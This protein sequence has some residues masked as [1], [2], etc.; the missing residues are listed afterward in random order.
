MDTA[1]AATSG[2]ERLRE[3]AANLSLHR[4][5]AEVVASLEAGHGG[6]LGGVWGSSRALVAAA[7]ARECPGPL[8]IVAPHPGEIDSIA[9]DLAIFSDA[10][11]AE[12]PAWESEPGERVVHDEIYGGRLRVLKA[13]AHGIPFS[14]APQ[15]PALPAVETRESGNGEDG[16]G[17]GGADA[18]TNR[19]KN[20]GQNPRQSRGLT[21]G[22]ALNPSSGIIVTSIQSLL[23]PVPGRDVLAEATREIRV[24]TALDEQEF[25]KWLVARGGHSTTAVELPGEFSLRGGILDIFPPDAD[26]PVRVELFGSDVESIRRFDVA[27]QRSLGALDAVEVTMLEPTASDRAHFTAYLPP[28]T[29]FLLI[30]PNELAEEGKFYLDRMDRPQ[31]FHSVRTTLDEIYKFPSVTAA[32]VPSGSMEQTAHLEF[33]S[34]ERFSGDI[35]K[36]RDE[37][38][39]VSVGQSVYIVCETVAEVER[40]SELFKTP[41]KEGPKKG[42]S[43]R[44]SD[45]ESSAID[46]APGKKVTVTDLHDLHFV[47]GHLT[48]GFRIV[49]QK[50]ALVSAAELFQRKDLTRSTRR[51]QSR[52][53][54][55]F[56]ELRQGDLV[57][58]LAHGIGRYRGLKLLEKDGRAEEHLELEYHGGTKIF[59]PSA[60]IELVQKY[61]GGKGSGAV[62]LAHIGGA[63]WVRQ[64][65]AAEKAVTDLAAEMIELQA[66]RDLRPGIAFPTD[67]EWQREF[68]GQFPYQETPD[69]ITSIADIKRDMQLQRPMDRLLCGDVGFGKTEMAIRAAFKAIDAGYQVAVLV[70]TTVLAEQH[71]RTFSARMAEFPFEIAALSRFCTAKETKGIL[72]RAADG[73]L[74]ILIGTHRMASPDVKF[75]NLGLLIIDEEQRFGV[76]VKEKLKALRATVDVLTMTAT[77]IPRT[78]HMSLLGV[79]AISNLET[80]PADRLAVETRVT[81][82][83]D[84]LIRHAIMRELGRG[85]QIYFVH[86]RINDIQAVAARLNRIVP[87]ARI[88]IG[89]GQMAEHQLEDV[90]VKF[91]RGETDIL[92]STT[93]VESG[94]DIPNANTMFI[95]DADRYG[96]ADLHQLRGRVGR[97]KH[98]AYCYLLVDENRHLS[99]EAAR[100]LRAIEEFSQMGAGFA[101]AMR[102][103]ELRGAGNILGTQQSGHIAMVGYEL[104]CALLER[105]VRDLKKLPPRDT[106]DVN[107]D[108]PG[109][110]YL[111]RGYVPDQRTKIDLY[112]RLARLTTEAAVG[113][114]ATELVDR[115]GSVPEVVEHLLELARVRIWA[116]GWGV[117]EIRLED[118]YAVLGYSSR[119]KL[120][121]LVKRSGG[122]LRVADAQSAYLPLDCRVDDA[123][124][125][126]AEVKALLQPTGQGA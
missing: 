31:A 113:D 24:G 27:T 120:A 112:R 37:L 109:E 87:E 50:V 32:G 104:Y 3:L 74:D 9:R 23:Q 17:V 85:G 70:P 60:K 82:F 29:W 100:R 118:R 116:H 61:V 90:M 10:A 115:F 66:Q 1:M 49:P 18:K 2:A 96:L 94:L 5:F 92:L 98:R 73:S 102:D 67:T 89:H 103:L 111:P 13:L 42:D 40:L 77:P 79:R 26:D 106:I 65:Q 39:K 110:A 57:V 36:V 88:D 43:H 21:G 86:N 16:E 119:D 107:I 62:P 64:K 22:N 4:G 58:H 46:R 41:P 12:F 121:R 101:L 38:D 122:R 28:E 44:F 80:P 99:P 34:V 47:V 126:F 81:R 56:L 95:D 14:H 97:Y 91:V 93:I 48:A 125:V 75:A 55:S 30:E 76:E 71:R 11:V 52:A 7:L 78:L 117:R 59:V 45:E 51:R 33:E 108:L 20:P 54:D 25:T 69:Q 105:A 63:A 124:G 35:A 114:F 8:V 6:T 83:S 15:P 72:E 68:E 84:D 53:I 19:R 123:A